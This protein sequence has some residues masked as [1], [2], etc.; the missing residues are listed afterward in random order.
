[1]RNN[2][3]RVPGFELDIEDTQQKSVSFY[4]YIPLPFEFFSRIYILDYIDSCWK[5]K[6]EIFLRC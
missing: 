2:V 6:M 3:S 5:E 4:T 1:M